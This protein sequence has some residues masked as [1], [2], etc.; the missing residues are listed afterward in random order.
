MI[1]SPFILSPELVK[2]KAYNIKSDVWAMGICLFYLTFFT[3][4]FNEESIPSL[5]KAIVHKKPM[6]PRKYFLI[7]H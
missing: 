7:A 6:I 3:F 4:P 5:L 2:K 1:G